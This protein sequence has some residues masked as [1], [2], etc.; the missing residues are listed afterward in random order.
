[1]RT[2]VDYAGDER[3][4]ELLADCR[5]MLRFA[6]KNGYSLPQT[7]IADLTELDRRLA[8]LGLETVTAIDNAL[9]ER[10]SAAQFI[11]A[12]SDITGEA[13][14]A[15][16]PKPGGPSAPSPV[17]GVPPSPEGLTGTVAST[18]SAPNNAP[19]PDREPTKQ[20]SDMERL[21]ATER[22]QPVSLTTIATTTLVLRVQDGLSAVIAPA[23]TTSLLASQPPPGPHKMLGGMPLFVRVTAGAALLSSLGFAIT[24]GFI[25]SNDDKASAVGL[26]AAS[27][28]TARKESAGGASSTGQTGK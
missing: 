17:S 15:A 13:R 12:T 25:A 20:S 24:S 16:S 19:L 5:L 6:T 14:S 23:T 26:R 2:T 27:D 8:T 28:G 4:P 10:D 9:L 7:L 18:T 11:A 22:L 21:A 3:T 1:M